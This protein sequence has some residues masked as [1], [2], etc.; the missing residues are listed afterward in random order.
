MTKA[1]QRISQKRKRDLLK[2]ENGPSF[3]QF[4]PLSP[5]EKILIDQYRKE[6]TARINDDVPTL[7]LPSNRIRGDLIRHIAL[8]G[9]HLTGGSKC[10]ITIEGAWIL[11]DLNFAFQTIEM[12]IMLLGCR[13]Y[14]RVLLGGAKISGIYLNGSDVTGVL[15]EGMHCEG[16]AFFR[17]GF[18]S[19]TPVRLAGATIGGTLDC[20]RGKFHKHNE[21]FALAFDSATI[22]R[23]VNLNDGFHAVGTVSFSDARIT[24]DVDCTDGRFNGDGSHAIVADG[25]NVT[26]SV[27]MQNSFL[28]TG[29]VAFF[30]ASIGRNLDCG[31]GRFDNADD[32]ALYCDGLIIGGSVALNSGFSASGSVY[33]DGARIEGHFDCE[34]GRF[35]SPN[36]VALS[37]SHTRIE[38]WCD[39]TGD[40]RAIGSVVGREAKIGGRFYCEQIFIDGTGNE[41]I[42]FDGAEIGG[43]TNF[44][45]SKIRGRV[46]LSGC[47]FKRDLILTGCEI[48]SYDT[49]ALLFQN[50][51]VHGALFFLDVRQTIGAIYFTASWANTLVDDVA[52]WESAFFVDLDGFKYDRLANVAP[53]NSRSRIEFLKHTA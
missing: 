50:S 39:L 14:G 27:L 22:D 9:H 52:S 33:F 1:A 41:A 32:V 10:E 6:E 45:S 37:F 8:N 4:E 38:F 21:G 47:E 18:I 5:A 43:D 23:G 28:A 15:A 19:R 34:D 26:G 35:D 25:A 11:G 36:D 53:T 2:K 51:K 17:D 40:F 24:G 30:N 29:T 16:D 44:N 13:I 31:G 48:E 12:P 20:S 49:D 7:S 46:A 3:Q 42:T